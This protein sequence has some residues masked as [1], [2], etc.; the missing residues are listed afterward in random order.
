MA[1]ASL[2]V[3][4]ANVPA[5][6]RCTVAI[7]W[8]GAQTYIASTAVAL[9]IG[10]FVAA[11]GGGAFLGMTAVGWVSF[12]IVW[13]FQMVLFWNGIDWIR[14]FRNRAAPAVYSVMIALLLILWAKAGS[15][16]LSEVGSIFEGQ[17][18]PKGGAFAAFTTVVGTMV[19]Y[20]AAVI[21]NF[22]DFSRYV[23]ST[24][25][26]RLGN[27]LGLPV[28]LAVFSLIALFVTAGTVVVFGAHLTDPTAIIRRVD[29]PILTVVAALT[30][31][32][33]TVGINVVANFVPP[34]NDL[35]N[36]MPGRIS[37]RLGGLIAACFAFVVGALW[38]T[39]ISQLGISKFVNTLGAILA[40][41]YGIMIVDFYLIRRGVLDI[42]DLYSAV[43]GGAYHYDRGWNRRA[44]A[45]FG[46][47][48]LFS[49]SA[50]WLPELDFLTGFDW[51]I[52]AVLGGALYY[53]LRARRT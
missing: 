39:A 8:D 31:F 30:F 53:G 11:A 45:A 36:L 1:R 13:S 7:Y 37:F 3:R 15:S 33:A 22:G 47:A 21:L 2:G 19:A 38:V 6:V 24:A 10:T 4:G 16:L 52:G 44:L 25:D 17:G 12:V 43:P 34:A 40:P 9:L 28:S 46:V 48:A 35:S 18:A 5:L 42:R 51:V 14:V 50:V 49:V 29:T 20:F 23:R 27:F 26:M 32:V 41:A